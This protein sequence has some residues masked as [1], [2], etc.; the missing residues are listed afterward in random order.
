[1]KEQFFYTAKVDLDFAIS[2]SGLVDR[3]NSYLHY[4]RNDD[5]IHLKMS[6]LLIKSR[7]NLLLRLI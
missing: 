7:N 2:D 1:M 4:I 5:N 3:L 6:L